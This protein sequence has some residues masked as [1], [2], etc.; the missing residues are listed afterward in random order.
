[1]AKCSFCGKD[2]Q[3][4]IHGVPICEDCEV[5][6]MPKADPPPDPTLAELQRECRLKLHIYTDSAEATC[7]T[8][9]SVKSL[10]LSPETS[11]KLVAQRIEEDDAQVEYQKARFDLMAAL[12][13]DPTFLKNLD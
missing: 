8:M 2:T 4:H 13:E 6:G 3:L 12:E 5:A 7:E 10:P 11:E 1:L 9:N